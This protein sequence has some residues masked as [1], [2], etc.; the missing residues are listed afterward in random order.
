MKLQADSDSGV[1]GHT[2]SDSKAVTWLLSYYY[3]T[4]TRIGKITTVGS[5]PTY[6]CSL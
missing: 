5:N 6:R 4:G 3:M 2:G 1:V